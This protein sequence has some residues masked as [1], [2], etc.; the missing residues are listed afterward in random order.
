MQKI[1]DLLPGDDPA[2]SI[3]LNV[4][5]REERDHVFERMMDRL[6]VV[7]TE[8]YGSSLTNQWGDT[9]PE[10]WELLLK[11]LSGDQIKQGLNKLDTRDYTGPP[12]AAEFR[13]LCLPE[14]TSPDGKNSTAYLS[15]DDPRHPQYETFRKRLPDMTRQSKNKESYETEMAKI[16]G[17]L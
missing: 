11:G 16:R 12:N 15:F 17:M 13:I 2:Q 3:G 4:P 7:L 14:K 10:S 9:I 1:A 8:I 5:A 6:W